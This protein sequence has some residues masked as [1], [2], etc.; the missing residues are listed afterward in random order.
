RAAL[1]VGDAP[2]LAGAVRLPRPRGAARA[3]AA[4]NGVPG[5]PGPGEEKAMNLK[6][7][8]ALLI[9]VALGGVLVW[10]RPHLPPQIDPTP[11]AP[12]VEDAGT[13][14]ELDRLD[15][16]RFRRIEVRGGDQVTVLQRKPDGT[17][18]LPGNWPTRNAEAQALAKGLAGLR[19]RF[20]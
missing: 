17:W 14:A 12:Q 8:F 6:S 10:Y 18:A 9:L 3:P 16:A 2:G 15:A 20:S 5:L 1:A 19:T 4:L 7:T 13:R 11:K